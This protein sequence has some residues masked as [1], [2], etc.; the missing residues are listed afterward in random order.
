MELQKYIGKEREYEDISTDTM[1]SLITEN[2]NRL[3]LDMAVLREKLKDEKI[4]HDNCG[5]NK[6]AK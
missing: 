1:L 5:S 3:T 2:L 6:E 4:Q